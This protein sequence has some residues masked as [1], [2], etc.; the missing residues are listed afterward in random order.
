MSDESSYAPSA[1]SEVQ[2]DLDADIA[3]D[4]R[5][6]IEQSVAAM[7]GHWV[8]LREREREVD[9]HVGAL[10]AAIMAPLAKL[11]EADSAAREEISSA[12][13]QVQ[14]DA[15]LIEPERLAYPNVRGQDLLFDLAVG[16]SGL[17]VFGTPFH[18]AWHWDTGSPAAGLPLLDR[19]TGSIGVNRRTGTTGN[20]QLSQHAG[21]GVS[22]STDRTRTVT[23]RSSRRT[24]SAYNVGSYGPGGA[25]TAEGGM[26][27]TV[28]E[29]GT[30]IR[31]KEDKVFRKRVSGFEHE[32]TF[33]AD[34]F[35]IGTP[36]EMTWTMIP[37][38]TYTFNVG[39]WVWCENQQPS[40]FPDT[41]HAQADLQ[42]KVLALTLS[43][44]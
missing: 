15:E 43:E 39:A 28:I 12:I 26:E 40:L 4:E 18:F 35:A 27:M 32:N 5:E 1:V 11:L 41:S 19:P 16:G 3:A 25:A 33:P 2:V 22:L 23:G 17:Q 21:F 6:R 34:G 14:R 7:A 20:R 36:I 31:F 10:D 13:A 38:S 8:E 37:G 42:A 44:P 29:N 24:A 30:L 9:A